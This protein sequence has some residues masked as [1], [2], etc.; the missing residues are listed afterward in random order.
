MKQSHIE[1]APS[2]ASLIESLRDVG[3][4]METALADVVDNSITA[5]AENIDIRYAWNACR[6][7]LAVIDD[8]TGM[9]AEELTEAMRFGCISPLEERHKD[10]LGRFGLGMKTASFSQC[11]HLTVFSVKNG[12]ASCCEWDLDEISKADDHRW[13]LNV[14]SE[15]DIESR[16]PLGSLVRQYFSDRVHGTAVLWEG[17]D[18][19]DAGIS[20]EKQERFLN[21]LV[22]DARE[23]LE[24]VFH[25]FLSPEPGRKAVKINHN[26]DALVGLDPFNSKSGATIE[27]PKETIPGKDG[28]KIVVQPYVLPHHNKISKEEYLKYAGPEGYLHNQGFY[29]YRNR[30]LIIRG[31]WFR[32]IK[33]AELTKLVRVQ[34][35]IPNSLDQLWKI[36]VQKSSA[37]PPAS[38]RDQLQ[39]II[40]KIECSGQQVYRQKGQRLQG[41]IKMPAWSRRAAEDKVF[42]EI[43]RNHPLLKSLSN[44]LSLDQQEQLKSVVR[45]LE[46]SFP[47][48]L[49]FSDFAGAPEKLQRPGI[50]EEQLA[51]MLDDFIDFWGMNDGASEEQEAELLQ[52]DPFSSNK[53]LTVRLLKQKGVR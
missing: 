37:P 3:Y 28:S 32:L 8:G 35:D 51:R 11:R 7:W 43:N 53:E 4:S 52:V 44:S 1:L 6:P 14:L 21:G 49:F 29:V 5:Q 22:L 30:R 2:P 40:G 48:D 38:V 27:L 24:L 19:M 13:L 46:S 50:E 23:H 31:T 12:V 9:S 20:S 36:D 15:R 41:A 39:R 47:S 33:K 10:D 42:Y 34:V 16:E 25:R 45:M 17:I 26:G 18:R